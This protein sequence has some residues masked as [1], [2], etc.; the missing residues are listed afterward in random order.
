MDRLSERERALHAELVALERRHPLYSRA[1]KADVERRAALTG[2][3]LLDVVYALK[4]E[5]GFVSPGPATIPKLLE[6]EKRFIALFEPDELP[7]EPDDVAAR[8]SAD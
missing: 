6:D 8:S 2:F 4:E 5:R 1:W 3:D 7:M